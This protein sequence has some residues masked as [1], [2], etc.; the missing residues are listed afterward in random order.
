[1]ST[2]TTN[3]DNSTD[4]TLDNYTEADSDRDPSEVLE[5]TSQKGTSIPSSC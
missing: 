3:V 1:M 4:A 2:K 5:I